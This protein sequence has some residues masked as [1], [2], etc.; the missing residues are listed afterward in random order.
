MDYLNK[1]C[2]ETGFS[3][4]VAVEKALMQYLESRKDGD[5]NTSQYK[6]R[7]K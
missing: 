6:A 1:F 7:S 5:S 4:T 2:E 3:K